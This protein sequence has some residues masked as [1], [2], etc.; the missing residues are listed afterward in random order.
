MGCDIHVHVEVKINGKWHH[1]NHPR[2]E[3]NYDIFTRMAG[4]RSEG[5]GDIKPISA[6]R[7]MPE[8]ATFITRYSFNRMGVDAHSA[9]WL[10]AQEV[11][12]LGEWAEA[13]RR[14]K[15]NFD[16]HSFYSFEHH[17]IGYIF[18]NGW[19]FKDYPKD[20]PEGL[21]DARAIFWFDN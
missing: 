1:Y 10:S 2:L 5:R 20:M 6:P 12:E 13:R 15:Y 11:A 7:G 16:K 21:E 19:N 8:D 17:E 18:R 3:R 9:S 4:V 14:D